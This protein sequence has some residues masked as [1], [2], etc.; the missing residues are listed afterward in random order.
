M[1]K[2]VVVLFLILVI[3][4]I[5]LQ[6]ASKRSRT[7]DPSIQIPG[8]AIN[9]MQKIDPERIRANVRFM[10]HDLIDGRGTCQRGGVIAAEYIATQLDLDGLQLAGDNGTFVQMFTMV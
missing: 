8:V 9:A 1:R 4:L 5:T 2:S 6:A 3:S 10:S 7:A